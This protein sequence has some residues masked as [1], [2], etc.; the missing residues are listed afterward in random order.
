LLNYLPAYDP[1]KLAQIFC[2]HKLKLNVC[3]VYV[4]NRGAFCHS[5]MKTKQRYED[6]LF[7]ITD[8]R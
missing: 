6:E 3:T 2:P 7:I 1:F 5:K 8:Y 4:F